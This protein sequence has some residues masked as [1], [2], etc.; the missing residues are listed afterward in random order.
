M[1][2]FSLLISLLSFTNTPEATTTAPTAKIFLTTN[3]GNTWDDFSK[4]LPEDV[5]PRN[6]TEENGDLYLSTHMHGVFL[7]A[8]N[9]DTWVS[10]RK[11]LPF[12]AEFFL[13]TS[14]AVKGDK[15]TLGTYQHGTFISSD[16]GKYWRPA[17]KDVTR[18]ARTLLYTEDALLAGT[19][20]GIFR[21]KDNGD[22]WERMYEDKT[23]I[24]VL[25]MHHDRLFIASQNGMGTVEDGQVVWSEM[26]SDW[27]LLQ[28]STSGEY[29]YF[30]NFKGDIFRSSNGMQWEA[31]PLVS[32]PLSCND[33]SEALWHGFRPELPTEDKNG[34]IH[35]TSRGWVVMAGGGC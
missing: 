11:G 2:F 10:I 3:Q 24:N 1:L 35:E 6:L 8:A 4:G 23:S 21:S 15:L 12:G 14:L 29:V 17:S 22:T 18:C 7:L 27:A 28:T 9:T 25:A 32:I 16:G 26:T 5:E 31:K 13:P 30:T 20:T 33:L 34:S 19:E